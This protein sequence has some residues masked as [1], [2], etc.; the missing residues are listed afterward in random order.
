[1]FTPN[2]TGHETDAMND[3]SVLL[4][5]L[6]THPVDNHVMTG[7]PDREPDEPSEI[8]TNGESLI[9]TAGLDGVPAA[10]FCSIVC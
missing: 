3:D 5:M 10:C 2:M 7:N 6:G 9:P 1:M 4:R 8:S